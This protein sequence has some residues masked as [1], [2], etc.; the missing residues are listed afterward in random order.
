[1]LCSDRGWSLLP[2]AMSTLPWYMAIFNTLSAYL[3]FVEKMSGC[4]RNLGRGYKAS[5]N[6]I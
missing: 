6:I 4:S 5:T 3:S 1:M 2:S